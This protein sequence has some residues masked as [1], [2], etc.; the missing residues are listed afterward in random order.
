MTLFPGMCSGP[1]N[2]SILRRAQ[3]KQL[4]EFRV[5]DLRGWTHDRHRV[6]DDVPYGGGSGM[7]LKP[8]PFFEAIDALRGAESQVLLL[9]P[10]GERFDQTMA[11][12][13]AEA[14]HLILLC[15]RYEGFDERVRSLADREISI[16]DYV[17]SGGELPALVLIDAV[18]RL[19]PGALGDAE[20]AHQ[21]SFAGG[22][23][24]HP[25]YTRPPVYRGLRVPEVL[26]S[27][28]HEQIRR[29][30]RKETLRRTLQRRPDLL[31]RAALSAEDHGFLADIRGTE[32]GEM[33]NTRSGHEHR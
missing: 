9:T 5:H 17:V 6:V 33:T 27:G 32:D 1:L 15:G 19:I 13:L 4:V 11:C 3:D 31:E 23:L 28:D 20:S 16:G 18:V 7:V 30:R 8:E 14:P 26:L 22:L 25:Q 2:E 29:W 21:D 12:R 24:E 10:Q